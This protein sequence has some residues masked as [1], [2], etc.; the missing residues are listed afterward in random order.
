[1]TR[2]LVA[3]SG[4]VDSSVAAARMVEEGHEVVGVTMK[5]WAG[6][7]G[8]APTSGCCTISD[9]EDARRVAAQLGIPYYVL[10]Y[11]DRFQVGVI[12]RFVDDYLHGR[13]PNPCVECNRTVKFR[14]L[15]DQAEDF[16]C[17]LLVTGHYARVVEREGRFGLLRGVD[18]AKDQ[19][20]VLSMLGQDQLRRTRLPI[21]ELDKVETRAIASELGLRTALKPESMDICFVGQGDYRSFLASVTDAADRAGPF[22]DTDG[23]VLGEHRGVANVTIGQRKGLGVAFGEPRYVVDV[24]PETAT[25][26]LG[27]RSDLAVTGVVGTHWTYVDAVP[28]TG[29]R[30]MAQYRAH[31]QVAEARYLGERIEFAAPQYGVAPG[32]T[33]ALYSGDAVVASAVIESTIKV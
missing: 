20:Y 33:I 27:S 11:T 23:Q 26:V 14:H 18:R 3:M 21:G 17:D 19:S 31:G 22:V 1:M 16:D 25:V 12:D 8:E 5:M 30:L 32:Q 2:V 10:D 4:G 29:A 7:N 24:I 28:E 6:P 15:L 9:T 13:T